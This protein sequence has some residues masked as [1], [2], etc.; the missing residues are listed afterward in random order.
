MI[1]SDLRYG[2][3]IAAHVSQSHGELVEGSDMSEAEAQAFFESLLVPAT[4]HLEYHVDID[5]HYYSAPWRF[6]RNAIVAGVTASTVEMVHKGA[7]VAAH[8]RS[9][10][11]RHTTIAEHMASA[12]R[13]FA[14]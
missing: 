10:N 7:R 12:H 8:R 6:A 11:S 2:C 14:D 9:S 3:A 1:A 5:K 13:R 4:D